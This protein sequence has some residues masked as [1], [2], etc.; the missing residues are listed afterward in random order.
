[1]SYVASLVLFIAIVSRMH[2]G[3]DLQATA[4][5]AVTST[6]AGHFCILKP[7]LSLSGL[8]CVPCALNKANTF[9]LL[10]CPGH[11]GAS[12]FFLTLNK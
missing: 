1:M 3:H 2:H 11:V 5:V 7:V 9:A 12:P 4:N 8:D 10:A 6:A